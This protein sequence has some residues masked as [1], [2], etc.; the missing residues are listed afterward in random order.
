MPTAV[1]QCFLL[2]VE[3]VGL[4][5]QLSPSPDNSLPDQQ[6]VL[7]DDTTDHFLGAPSG[8]ALTK[9]RSSP[10]SVSSVLTSPPS[11]PK[12]L[13]KQSLTTDMSSCEDLNIEVTTPTGKHHVYNKQCSYFSLVGTADCLVL[14]VH[15]GTVLKSTIAKEYDKATVTDT[16]TRLTKS[17]FQGQGKVAVRMVSCDSLTTEITQIMKDLK[18][19]DVRPLSPGSSNSDTDPANLSS[20]P[21]TLMAALSTE[22]KSYNSVLNDVIAAANLEYTSF[23]QTEEGQGFTGQVTQ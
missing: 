4:E 6:K 23:L 12:P 16:I 19:P 9:E 15:G 11:S 20:L 14:I 17:H 13:Y 2:C 3:N 18:P 8:C 22:L 21:I 1:L 5:I 7:M 10:S